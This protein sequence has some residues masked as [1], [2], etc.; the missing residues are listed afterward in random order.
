MRTPNDVDAYR[1]W[2]LARAANLSNDPADSADAILKVID[3]IDR[4][5]PG[6]ERMLRLR[7]SLLEDAKRTDQAKRV[8]TEAINSDQP[9]SEETLLDL[10]RRSQRL[11]LNLS[12]KALVA[13]CGVARQFA[14][15]HLHPSNQ[16]GAA[17]SGRRRAANLRGP[18]EGP[19]R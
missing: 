6:D 15:G 8:L 16:P 17:G 10:A 12:E 11:G 3:E 1:A 14:T 7:L 2:A 18:D 4:L 5:A 19:R 9:L 13:Q